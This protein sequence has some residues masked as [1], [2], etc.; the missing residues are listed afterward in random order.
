MMAC[1]KHRNRKCPLKQVNIIII[2]LP[3]SNTPNRWV[4]VLQTYP[5]ILSPAKFSSSPNFFRSSSPSLPVKQVYLSNSN[6]NCYKCICMAIKWPD[7]LV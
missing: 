3:F 6:L 1:L 5:L 7:K 4:D 2:S